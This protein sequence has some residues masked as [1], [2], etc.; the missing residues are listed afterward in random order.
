MSY[1]QQWRILAARIHS[2]TKAGQLY[3]QL[4]H[5]HD[6]YGRIDGTVLYCTAPWEGT[7]VAST[8][9]NT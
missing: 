4:S 6:G 9:V 2:L 7:A 8:S 1:H 3:G 5:A